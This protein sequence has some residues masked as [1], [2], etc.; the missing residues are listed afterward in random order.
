[1]FSYFPL[2]PIGN[3]AHQGDVLSCVNPLARPR[4]LPSYTLFYSPKQKRYRKSYKGMNGAKT[5]PFFVKCWLLMRRRR[6]PFGSE[7]CTGPPP[8]TK[9]QGPRTRPLPS[10]FEDQY[11]PRSVIICRPIANTM[12]IRVMPRKNRAIMRQTTANFAYGT[13]ASSA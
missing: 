7:G 10:G 6:A 3:R 13:E 11:S 9:K 4:V 8:T 12:E 5:A 1:M 2:F